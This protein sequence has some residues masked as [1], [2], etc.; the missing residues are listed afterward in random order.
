MAQNM[1][2]IVDQKNPW[3]FPGIEAMKRSRGGNNKDRSDSEGP[4]KRRHRDEN[5]EEYVPRKRRDA[6]KRFHRKRTLKEALWEKD[7][8]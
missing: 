1:L 8:G 3:M 2:A 7:G 6:G 4:R 5:G